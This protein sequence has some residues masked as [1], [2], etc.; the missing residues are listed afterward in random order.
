MKQTD[1]AICLE[2]FPTDYL[3]N[4]R[5]STPQKPLIPT[6]MHSS[7]CLIIMLKSFI[8]PQTG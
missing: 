6:V 5:G 4:K 8:Y 7:F 1:F 2:P 3:V